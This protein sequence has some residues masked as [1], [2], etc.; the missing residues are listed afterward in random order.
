M[1]AR[2]KTALVDEFVYTKFIVIP[3]M[4]CKF[5]LPSSVKVAS[6]LPLSMAQTLPG[7]TGNVFAIKIFVANFLTFL[8]K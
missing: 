7:G 1:L 4:N 8:V 3:K 6:I 5:P 2:N